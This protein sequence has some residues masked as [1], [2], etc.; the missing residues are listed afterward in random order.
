MMFCMV[1]VWEVYSKA[2]A[3]DPS[4][5]SS[6]ERAVLNVLRYGLYKCRPPSCHHSLGWIVGHT[7]IIYKR[8]AKLWCRNQFSF[9]L[10]F[11]GFSIMPRHVM[12]VVMEFLCGVYITSDN[13]WHACVTAFTA[14]TGVLQHS[15]LVLIYRKGATTISRT[16]VYS[17]AKDGV[18]GIVLV[19]TNPTCATQPRDIYSK[20]HAST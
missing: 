16:L 3:R 6:S 8:W 14:N 19:C 20:T 5:H 7:I 18:W 1:G 13:I 2:S 12:L 9:V 10:G 15:P 11:R 4:W 17:Q